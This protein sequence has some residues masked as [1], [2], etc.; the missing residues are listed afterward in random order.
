MILSRRAI[1]GA[2]LAAGLGLFSLGA[3]LANSAAPFSEAAF[4][5]A[6]AS[7]S[8]I[9]V[10]IHADWCPTCKAQKPI[11]EKLTSDAKFKNLKVFRVDFDSQKAVVRQFGAQ[12]QST[13]I[14][15]KGATEEGRSVGDT[16][17][18]SIGALL[19]KSL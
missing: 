5:A 9:L 15:Y 13:L 12:M 11:L 10:E 3:A 16:R 6:Q 1:G 4:K 18:A 7:G 14:V 19:D 2:V 8:S 17:Q